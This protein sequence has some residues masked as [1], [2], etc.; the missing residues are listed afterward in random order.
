M[1]VVSAGVIDFILL[2]SSNTKGILFLPDMIAVA[3][4]TLYK[5]S[6]LQKHI[7]LLCFERPL[8]CFSHKHQCYLSGSKLM[9]CPTV[10]GRLFASSQLTTIALCI[11]IDM[12]ETI[13]H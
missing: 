11:A 2:L 4:E 5:L 10:G 1:F 8:F 9:A 6:K 7:A 13:G 12:I 3:Y